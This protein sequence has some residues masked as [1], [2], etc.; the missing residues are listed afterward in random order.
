MDGTK[1]YFRNIPLYNVSIALEREGELIAAAVCRPAEDVVYSAGKGLGSY[2]NGE[3]ISV[4]TEKELKK[5]FVYCYLPPYNNDSEAYDNNW[6]K[7]RDLGKVFYR[8]RV[9]A[10]ANSSLCWLAQ[11]GCEAYCNFIKQP[12]YDIA[13]GIIIAKEAGAF[14]KDIEGN[15]LGEN[16]FKSLIAANSEETYKKIVALLGR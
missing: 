14:V 16:N 15:K 13:S 10:D 2:R 6:N 5:S 12:W 7:L 11:G 4:S 8:V 9:M 3:K 1:E